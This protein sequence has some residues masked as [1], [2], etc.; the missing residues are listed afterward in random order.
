MFVC[1]PSEPP[2]ANAASGL[3][4]PCSINYVGKARNGMPRWW[5]TSHQA[6]AT[7]P[8]G[9]R[10]DV[11][12]GAGSAGAP[13]NVLSIDPDDYPGGIAL[14]GVARPVYDTTSRPTRAGVHVHARL[15]AGG[16]K[17]IDDSYDAVRLKV[18]TDLFDTTMLITEAMARA[19][20]LAQFAGNELKALPCPRC[21]VEH[22]DEDWFSIKPHR[23][24]LCGA[25]GNYFVDREPSVSNPVI[26]VQRARAGNEN[27][28][29]VRAPHS[30]SIDQRDCPGGVQLWASNRAIL[31]TSPKAE[32]EGIHVH[33]YDLHGHLQQDD[34]FDS[35]SIDGVPLDESMI[36]YLMAQHTVD[37]LANKV[38]TL[39]CP[40]CGRPHFDTDLCAFAPH[41]AHTCEHCGSHFRQGRRALVSNPIV[42]V[43]DSLKL[44]APG[45][46]T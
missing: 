31:W 9:L 21:G 15:K 8:K 44:R 26:G 27:P 14:W 42:A 12:A 33:V 40:E 35:V 37:G 10:L 23:R 5:C 11:C 18:P 6:N 36:K 39:H 22:L 28:Q 46:T 7:G 34:T 25:C 32:E 16:P 43:L 24:H 3:P 20:Y 45:S 30:L 2:S 17:A 41:S 1:H 38:A 29:P 4:G 13:R 19:S